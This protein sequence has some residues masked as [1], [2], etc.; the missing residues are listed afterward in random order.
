M[1]FVS[2][3]AGAVLLVIVLTDAF[4]TIV[5]AR[6]VKGMFRPTRL[7][8][9]ATWNLHSA[10]AKYFPSGERRESYLG[11]YG[12]LSV[13]LLLSVWAVL[14]MLAYGLMQWAAGLRAPGLR[15]TFANALYFS[16]SA[17]F[18]ISPGSPD[19]TISRILMIAEAGMGF[20]FLALVIGYLPVL[21]QS[22]ASR[23]RN[24]TLLDARGGSPPSA[25]ELLRREADDPGRREAQLATW[26]SWCAELLESHISYPMLAYFRSQHTNQSW[27]GSITAIVDASALVLLSGEGSL[28]RQ[29]EL[30]FAMGRH[31]LVDLATVFSAEPEDEHDRLPH[32]EFDRLRNALAWRAKGVYEPELGRLRESYEPYA[33]ALA[34]HFLVTL[35]PWLPRERRPDNWQSTP[36]HRSGDY[37]VSDAFRHSRQD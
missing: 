14:L 34:E 37:A 8:Y 2:A 32:D 31:A 11:I 25:G 33:Q 4:N 36:Q 13:L 23:E 5:L 30:T 27:L 17:A 16:G 28:R 3:L 21:Y 20:G 9:R 24:I 19:N 12:P 15:P 10:M 35:P 22:F 18:T 29:A 26:E 7:F 6:R 1:R